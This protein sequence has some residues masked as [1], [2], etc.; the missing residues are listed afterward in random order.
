[1]TFPYAHPVVTWDL[2]SLGAEVGNR[3]PGKD[4]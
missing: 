2:G 3:S 1:M 4:I